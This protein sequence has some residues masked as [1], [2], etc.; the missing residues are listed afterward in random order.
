MALS[1]FNR[2][3]TVT[4]AHVHNFS[5]QSRPSACEP[6][7]CR[8]ASP[9]P[10]SPTL[11]AVLDFSRHPHKWN[12][13]DLAFCETYF[14]IP[15]YVLYHILFI[16]SIFY[17]CLSYRDKFYWS[18]YCHVTVV[19]QRKVGSEIPPK[20]MSGVGPPEIS[21][22]SQ[23]APFSS[24]GVTWAEYSQNGCLSSS[25]Q[26]SSFVAFFFLL[27]IWRFWHGLDKIEISDASLLSRDSNNS[28]SLNTPLYSAKCASHMLLTLCGSHLTL[29]LQSLSHRW[30]HWSSAI[31][32]DLPKSSVNGKWLDQNVSPCAP[33]SVD[34]TVG[35]RQHGPPVPATPIGT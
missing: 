3:A 27:F 7:T 1:P 14:R 29:V 10:G 2:W 16:N 9:A 35:A 12:H 23:E 15:L 21:P 5:T 26:C 33:N 17:K 24:S 18:N 4:T 20:W 22:R 25:T 28:H 31:F 32:R 19:W 30:G 6:L 8:S 13:L 34:P 11:L